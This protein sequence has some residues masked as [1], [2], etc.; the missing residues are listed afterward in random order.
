MLAGTSFPE[1]QPCSL[2]GSQLGN[3]ADDSSSPETYI[4]PSNTVK[5]N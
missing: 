5:T 3:A 2:Q 4:V 1:G